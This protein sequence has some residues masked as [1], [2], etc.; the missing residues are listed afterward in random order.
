MKI[1]KNQKITASKR[2][3][4]WVKHQESIK[5]ESMF[6]D[7]SFFTRDDEIE[8]IEIPLED[9]L[10]HET[11]YG[12]DINTVI[13]LRA[14][15]DEDSK[16]IEVDCQ[17]DD[18]EFTISTQYD[19]RKIRKPNDLQKYVTPLFWEFDEEYSNCTDDVEACRITGSNIINTCNGDYE[20]TPH[21]SGF[22]V[23]LDGDEVFF[24]TY[25]E[26]LEA[27]MEDAVQCVEG[28]TEVDSK[29]VPLKSLKKG[30]WFTLK[31]IAEPKDSQVYI[32]DEYDREEKK[33]MCGRCD[34]ISYTKYLSGDKLVYTDFIY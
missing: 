25:D 15:I 34:D 6:G 13:N 19:M 33:F 8:Y 2:I 9:R 29:P 12:F 16:T 20:I 10:R 17:V 28:A 11:S 21:G 5:A 30:D 1:T 32:K 14:Y 22:T 7:D 18:F 3:Q 23:Q 27:I 4:D 26:A 24:K 31:P